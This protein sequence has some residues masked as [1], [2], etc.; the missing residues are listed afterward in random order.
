MPIK[1]KTTTKEDDENLERMLSNTYGCKMCG[2][3]I[4]YEVLKSEYCLMCNLK[5]SA[6]I[7]EKKKKTAKDLETRLKHIKQKK[8]KKREN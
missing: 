3:P 5:Y 7:R 2:K 8:S 4:S 1:Y 6:Q